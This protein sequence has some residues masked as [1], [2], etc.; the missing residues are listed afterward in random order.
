MDTDEESMNGGETESVRVGKNEGEGEQTGEEENINE[1][2]MDQ[3]INEVGN[4][5]SEIGEKERTE[6]GS[7]SPYKQ[8]EEKVVSDQEAKWQ[9]PVEKTVVDN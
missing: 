2:T 7:S 1:C 6:E 4:S 5:G 9:E 3:N 8:G